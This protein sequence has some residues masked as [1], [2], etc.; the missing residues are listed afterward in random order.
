MGELCMGDLISPGTRVRPAED[1][2][3]C[4]NLLVD[5]FCFTV[6]LGVVD[7]GEGEIIVQEFPKLLGKG[8]GELWTMI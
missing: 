5:T 1:L 2:K 6:Q 7:S 4:L 3:V 8:G